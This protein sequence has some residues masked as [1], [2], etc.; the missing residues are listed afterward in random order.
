MVDGRSLDKKAAAEHAD[1]LKTDETILTDNWI[2][3][4][5]FVASQLG[6][7]DDIRQV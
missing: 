2:G 7:E 3:C 1:L 6:D 5:A 4:S